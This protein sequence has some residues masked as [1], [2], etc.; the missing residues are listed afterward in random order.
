M[1]EKCMA[2][3]KAQVGIQPHLWLRNGVFYCRIELSRF[4][5]KRRYLCYSLHTNSYYEALG[6]MDEIEEFNEKFDR[7]CELYSKIEVI[8]Y[9]RGS[10][11]SGYY[12]LMLNIP[13][14]LFLSKDNDPKTIL[15]FM[16]LLN[17]VNQ[18]IGKYNVQKE[19]LDKLNSMEDKYKLCEKSIAPDMLE[20]IKRSIMPK[21]A[22]PPKHTLKYML[23]SMLMKANNGE[24]ETIR[25]RHFF[26]GIFKDL[27][28]SLD[29]DY[30][31][32][33]TIENIQKLSE[34]IVNKKDIQNDNKRQKLRYIKEFVCFACELEPDFYKKNILVSI[35]NLEKTKGSERQPHLPYSETQLKKLFNPKHKFFEGEPDLFWICMIALFTGARANAAMTLQYNNVVSKDGLWC[36]H[37]CENHP[38]KHLKNDASER[39]VPIHKQFLD[40]GFVDYVDRKKSKLKAGDEDFIFPKCQTKSGE[41]NNKYL[42]RYLFKFLAE[43]GLKGKGYDFHS[44]RK[45]ASLAL[46]SAGLIPTII[47]SIIGWEGK[48]TMEQSYSNYN[49]KQINA[50]L[51]KFSYDYLQ[52]EFDKWKKVMGKLP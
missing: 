28:L 31:K 1:G 32:F 46:Q 29:D 8:E 18:N 12:G 4:E 2:K 38:I 48:G 35:P 33:H 39:F 43:I 22:E 24:A 27:N 5:G 51:N 40:L 47:N 37:F 41:Y 44:F 10:L 9:R 26:E 17:E 36:I 14:G 3:C 52:P 30:V 11:P 21:Q 23:D 15:D 6:K 7:L 25:K 19:I 50:E 13:D 42:D 20:Q 16:K 49:L 45:N 34:D